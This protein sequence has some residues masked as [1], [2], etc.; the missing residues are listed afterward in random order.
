MKLNELVKIP[1]KQTF[2]SLA[3]WKAAVS[4]IKGTSI[5]EDAYDEDVLSAFGQRGQ[6]LGFFNLNEGYGEV[7]NRL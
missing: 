1:A 5:K 4:G 7:T 2:S 6:V 3:E